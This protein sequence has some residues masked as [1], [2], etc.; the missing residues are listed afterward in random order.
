MAA[1]GI[2]LM[3]LSTIVLNFLGT[4]VE[5]FA[6][7]GT[8]FYAR[9]SVLVI[10]CAIG[11]LIWAI[12]AK[13][14]H[15]DFVNEIAGCTFGVY[16]IHENNYVRPWLWQTVFRNAEWAESVWLPAHMIVA[17]LITFVVCT[18]IEFVRRKTIE[19]AYMPAVERLAGWMEDKVNRL[20]K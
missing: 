11:L 7:R 12:N 14:W 19:R 10:T 17:V 5:F 18:A 20:F 6:G 3:W 16:L 4:K 15:S 13:P 9:T 8:W 2:G 1:A